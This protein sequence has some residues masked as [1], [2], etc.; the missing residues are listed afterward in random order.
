MDT[1]PDK[2]EVYVKTHR[3]PSKYNFLRDE[4]YFIIKPYPSA[5]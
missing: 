3:K 2:M 1:I 4:E 5:F